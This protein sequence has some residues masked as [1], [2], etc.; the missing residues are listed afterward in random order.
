MISRRIVFI[1]SPIVLVAGVYFAGPNPS[2]PNY[3]YDL[4]TTPAN[5]DALEQFVAAREAQHKLK[6]DNEARIVWADSTKRKTEYAIVYLPGFSASHK[7][8]EPIH[9]K[10]ANEFGCNLFLA[11]LADHG[12]DTVDALLNFTAERFW[13]SAKEALAIGNQ[14]G[15]KVIL[16]STS[17]G[18][19]VALMLAAYFPDRVY[20]LI[21]LSPNIALRDPAAFLLNN[22][23]GLQI[24]RKVMGG[25]YR[26][27]VAAPER[28]KYWYSKYR[29]ESLVQLEE[30]LETTMTAETFSR[31]RQPVL[32]LYYY[33]SEKEQD[34]EVSIEAILSMH[35]LLGT[36]DSLKVIISV[37]NAGAHV[38]GSSMVSKDVEGVYREMVKFGVGRLGMH[39]VEKL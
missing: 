6:P 33:K 30:L 17:T 31:V 21:N 14:L 19:T 2:T 28:Q 5:P 4:P 39:A 38:I 16:V 20:S 15:D 37:P 1:L 3:N 7:E 24:A 36:D 25:D 11:R 29:I 35:E 34:P 10:F 8:G 23:W 18:G 13:N 22:P 32:T 26:E 27:W 9:T 12:I